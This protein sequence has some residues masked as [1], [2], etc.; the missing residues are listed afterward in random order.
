MKVSVMSTHQARHQESQTQGKAQQPIVCFTGNSSNLKLSLLSLK[1]M[2]LDYITGIP[3][4]GIK[5]Y[6]SPYFC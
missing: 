6:I 5:T 1:M 2:P 4:L 3:A